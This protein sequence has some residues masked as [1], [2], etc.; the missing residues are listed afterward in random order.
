MA[1]RSAPLT[2]QLPTHAPPQVEDMSQKVAEMHFSA[3][4]IAELKFSPDGSRLAAGSHDCEIDI[5]DVSKGCAGHLLFASC[6]AGHARLS[7][8]SERRRWDDALKASD[9]RAM[10]PELMQRIKHCTYV[11]THA[12]LLQVRTHGALLRPLLLHQ[13]HR[14][15]GRQP[16]H[17]VHVRRIRAALL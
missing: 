4:A 16:H 3:Q 1:E 7:T 9:S 14:L 15:V 5:F 8:S 17:P 10:G 12:C 11:H 13:A 6:G 2:R